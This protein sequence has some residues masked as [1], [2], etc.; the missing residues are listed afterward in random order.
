MDE[1]VTSNSFDG[2]IRIKELIGKRVTNSK[3]KQ[4]GKIGELLID[5]NNLCL[6]GI[7]VKRGLISPDLFVNQ[8]S[9][10]KLNKDGIDLLPTPIIESAKIKVFDM[11]GEFL[12]LVKSIKRLDNSTKIISITIKQKIAIKQEIKK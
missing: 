5:S 11:K 3:G 8:N 1:L 10:K 2:A 12:G 6:K 4:I 9:I 7:I